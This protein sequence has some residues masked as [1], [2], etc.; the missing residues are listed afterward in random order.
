MPWGALAL[1]M[2]QYVVI[3]CS[4]VANVGRMFV[5][6]A[7]FALR[8]ARGS[9]K[10]GILFLSMCPGVNAFCQGVLR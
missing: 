6:W 2:M 3:P 5:F 9:G 10:R 7:Y 1:L 4:Q 8:H